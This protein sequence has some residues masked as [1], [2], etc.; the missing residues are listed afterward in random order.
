MDDVVDYLRSVD[1][2]GL[3]TE[4]TGLNPFKDTMLIVSVGDY[5]NQF[6]IDART[7]D[8]KRI[9]PFL[10]S[11]KKLKILA[12]AGFDYKFFKQKGITLNNVFDVEVADLALNMGKRDYL[13]GLNVIVG[14][15]LGAYLS[16]DTRSTFEGHTGPFTDQQ[17]IYAA[18]DVKY[19]IP[20]KDVMKARE[21][22]EQIATLNIESQMALVLADM[23]LE[24]IRLDVD[25]W[26]ALADKASEER[27]R[28]H[29]ELDKIILS[30]KKYDRFKHKYI[31]G[32][33]FTDFKDLRKVNIQWTSPKQVLK[34]LQVEAPL[35]CTVDATELECYRKTS[36][37]IATYLEF[38]EWTKK[39]TTYGYDFLEHL[40]PDGRI[41]THFTPIVSTGRLSSRNP[42]MQNIPAT[43]EYRNCFIPNYDDCVFVNSDYSSQELTLIAEDSKDP[44]W[45]N[46]LQHGQDLHSVCAELLFGKDW[47][48]AADEDCAYFHEIEDG[49]VLTIARQKCKCKKHKKLRDLVKTLNFGLAYGMSE[50][51]LS[52]RMDISLFEASELLNKYFNT[53]PNIKASLERSATMGR[54]KGYIRL[55]KPTYA[56]RIFPEWRGFATTDMGS[57]ERKSKNTRIQG[58]GAYMIK[59]ALVRVRKAIQDENLP[60]KIVLTVHDEIDTIC[61]KDYAET[62]KLKL[63]SIM[64]ET[65]KLTVPSGLLKVE[66]GVFDRWEK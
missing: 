31:Q 44:V 33:L 55:M 27:A 13:R 64:E 2:F 36:Q 45:L 23:E 58:T 10:E 1:E 21:K 19:L 35:L 22:E 47:K 56:K 61:K 40:Y 51:T 34:V 59:I 28:L 32:D 17:I 26:K 8:L 15:Y 16:K 3:D 48:D 4:D 12:N 52:E 54:K 57:I 18:D 41:R 63:K 6:V 42:N 29:N 38:S 7:A 50:H 62:W 60:V 5:E 20:L 53:F 66:V 46:A 24:G 11:Y 9:V 65:A 43:N 14:E 39:A 25:A 30:D 37:L 49:G